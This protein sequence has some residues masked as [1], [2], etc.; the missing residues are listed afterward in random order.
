M[1]THSG[2]KP[3]KCTQCN[4]A[5]AWN[6]QLKDHVK[7]HS[8]PNAVSCTECQIVF[9][10]I[11]SLKTHETKEHGLTPGAVT[12]TVVKDAKTSPERA[13]PQQ[14]P[15]STV[16]SSMY[17]VPQSYAPILNYSNPYVPTNHMPYMPHYATP[18][19]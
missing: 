5:A 10:D 6:V 1:R 3:Y 17:A 11:R 15:V 13:E 7:A 16:N 19:E 8:L 14:I 18:F 12:V 9:K 2:E 4:Y